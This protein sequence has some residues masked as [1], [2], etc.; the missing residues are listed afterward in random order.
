MKRR[1][2]IEIIKTGVVKPKYPK[3]KECPRC[4]SMLRYNEE[5]IFVGEI[6]LPIY[7]NITKEKSKIEKRM[8][9]CPVC[10]F[11]IWLTFLD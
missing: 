9:K 6:T 1:N 8:I 5:D 11:S 10:S 3:R 4:N 2:N 7:N